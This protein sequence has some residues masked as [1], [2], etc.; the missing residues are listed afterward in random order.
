[1]LTLGG[2]RTEGHSETNECL[3]SFK[4]QSERNR[5]TLLLC[6]YSVLYVKYKPLRTPS[7]SSLTTL[8]S[9]LV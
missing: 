4:I 1:M 3:Q 7:C 8:E 6:K 9:S 2:E 5:S